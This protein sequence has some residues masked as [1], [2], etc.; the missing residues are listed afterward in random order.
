MGVMCG[1]VRN[2]VG[3]PSN[4]MQFRLGK[5]PSTNHGKGST[6]NKATKG[7]YG[8]GMNQE[9]SVRSQTLE[10]MRIW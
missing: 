3:V 10:V 2:C 9:G 4:E 1:Q 8:W 6:R 7:A 5:D